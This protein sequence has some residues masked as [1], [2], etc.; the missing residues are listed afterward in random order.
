MTMVE[1]G[2][3]VSSSVAARR[4]AALV[5]RQIYKPWDYKFRRIFI[6]LP[7]P[8]IRAAAARGYLAGEK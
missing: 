2:A 3:A 1:V 7:V 8:K 4:S 5:G 6:E